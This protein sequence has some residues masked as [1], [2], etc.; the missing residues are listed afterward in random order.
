MP[1]AARANF[2]KHATNAASPHDFEY[3]YV[4]ISRTYR[5]RKNL[6]DVRTF[7]PDVSR[8]SP[9][10]GTTPGDVGTKAGD[11]GNDA[12]DVLTNAGDVPSGSGNV[13]T[14]GGK[15]ATN[16]RKRLRHSLRRAPDRS[17][18]TG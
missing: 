3:E 9:D 10:V 11:V 18:R 8:L 14:A 15:L 16:L 4:G 13:Q 7:L 17:G 2:K 1:P 5:E 12:G 6:P